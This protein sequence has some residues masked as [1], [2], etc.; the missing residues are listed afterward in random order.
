MGK[1]GG[2]AARLSSFYKEI[3]TTPERG[4]GKK[5]REGKLIS[6]KD[7]KKG[8][9]EK[10]MFSSRFLGLTKAY[11]VPRGRNERMGGGKSFIASNAFLEKGGEGKKEKRL[12]VIRRWSWYA[13]GE[14]ESERKGGR[15]GGG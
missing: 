3:I 11:Q 4:R 8:G 5:G 9:E 6:R 10:K 1:G 7:G 14:G 15:K 2:R 12:L 13:R